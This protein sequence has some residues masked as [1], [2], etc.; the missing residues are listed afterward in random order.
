MCVLYYSVHSHRKVVHLSHCRIL[1]RIPKESRRSFNSLEEAQRHGYRLC[2]CCPPAAQKYRK[3][4]KPVNE[5]CRKAG[6][7]LKLK[8]GAIHII[9]RHDCWRIITCGKSNKLFLYHKNTSRRYGKNPH[10]SIIPGYHSQAVR[11]DT[12]LR[13]LEYIDSHDRYRDK[14][15]CTEQNPGKL[16]EVSNIPAWI[17][18]KYGTDHSA[19]T[20]SRYR[21]KK[22]TKKYKK[23]Q[24]RK[25]QLERRAAIIRVDALLEELSAIGY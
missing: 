10:P 5:F 18:D 21:K 25:K 20:V 11:S 14:H 9:S 13:Y 8:D 3:E 2:N 1:H 15:P 17:A 16:D 22:G 24:A 6:F 23:E 4:R 7:V 12:I 19:Y